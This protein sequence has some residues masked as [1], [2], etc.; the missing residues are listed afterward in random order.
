MDNLHVA[1]DG[2]IFVSTFP[3]ILDWLRAAVS[4]GMEPG[5]KSPVETWRITNETS[6]AQ[7]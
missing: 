7:L 1:P 5:V 2:A 6:E 4:G 3:R